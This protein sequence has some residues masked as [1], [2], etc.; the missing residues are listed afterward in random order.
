MHGI[1]GYLLGVSVPIV[2]SNALLFMNTYKDRN[3]FIDIYID[4]YFN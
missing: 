4:T 1:F 2:I 3:R